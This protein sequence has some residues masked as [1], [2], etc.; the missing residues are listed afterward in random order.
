M[1]RP[2]DPYTC[3]ACHKTLT[4]SSI[5]KRTKALSFCSTACFRTYNDFLSATHLKPTSHNSTCAEIRRSA[6]N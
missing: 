6:Y 1:P 4:M 2:N 3:V 5:Y